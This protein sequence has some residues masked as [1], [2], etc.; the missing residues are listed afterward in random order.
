MRRIWASKE[1]H[2]FTYAVIRRDGKPLF[3]FAVSL[4]VSFLSSNR[5]LKKKEKKF[6]I[7]L[8]LEPLVLNF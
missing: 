6:T 1:R 2:A 7:I 8:Y 3:S 5:E 4:K